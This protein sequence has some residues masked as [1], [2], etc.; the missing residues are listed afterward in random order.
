MISFH[1]TIT[2]DS[3]DIHNFNNDLHFF[4]HKY[5]S[6]PQLSVYNGNAGSFALPFKAKPVLSENSFTLLPFH[7]HLLYEAENIPFCISDYPATNVFYS[8]GK[9]KEQHFQIIHSQKIDSAFSITLN[10]KLINA[11]GL[12]SSQRTNQGHFYGYLIYRHKNR[13]Y[14]AI[15][16]ITQNKIQQRENGGLTELSQFEDSVLYDR[17]F[18][19]VNFY[20]AE[21][22][23]RNFTGYIKQYYALTQKE[24]IF[25]LY[26]GHESKIITQK[27]NFSD[28]DPAGSP[29]NYIF[30]DSTNT[31][32]STYFLNFSNSLTLSNFSPADSVLPAF[33]YWIKYQNCNTRVRKI[34]TEDIYLSNKIAAGASVKIYRYCS[35]NPELYYYFGPYNTSDYNVSL[36]MKRKYNASI[37]EKAGLNISI[38]KIHPQYIYQHFYSNHAIWQNEY[39]AQGLFAFSLD[40]KT[41]NFALNAGYFSVS[42]YVFLNEYQLPVQLDEKTTIFH[43]DLSGEYSIRNFFTEGILGTNQLNENSPYRF[44]EFYLQL[45]AGYEFPMFKKALYTFIGIENIWFSSFSANSWSFVTGLLH[46]QNEMKIGNYNYPGVFVGVKIKRARIFIMMENITAGL[47]KQNYYAMPEYPR[48]DRFFRWGVSWTFFN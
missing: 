33:R 15:G 17:Q 30:L 4:F 12:Y 27:N 45:R 44:P 48:Y 14:S 21:R 42:D 28:P 1:E 19:Q 26:I 20:N 36:S 22:K 18:A 24:S 46:V 43:A 35:L 11:P 41:S 32:D 34:G 5:S 8:S 39:N 13:R 10:Y 6:I 2:S 3:T 23:Y 16:G 25:P 38:S 47:T 29:Y 31:Y 37:I 40:L 9:N 7:Q